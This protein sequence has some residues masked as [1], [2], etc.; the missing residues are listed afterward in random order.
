MKGTNPPFN[1]LATLRTQ[2]AAENGEDPNEE[3]INAQ[4]DPELLR[5]IQYLEDGILPTEDKLTRKIVLSKS[6]YVV[7]D[8]VLYHVERDKSLRLVP[9]EINRKKLF[10]D[11]HDGIYGGQL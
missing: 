6:Q 2:V 11:V 9:P 7:I 5:V 4:N 1:I 8:K 3:L 10:Y